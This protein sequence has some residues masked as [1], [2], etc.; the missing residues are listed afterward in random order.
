MINAVQGSYVACSSNAIL[1]LRDNL[2]VQ[3]SRVKNPER[4]WD[5]LVVPNFY[6]TLRNF[7]EK[8]RSQVLTD[9]AVI[10][11]SSVPFVC[12]VLQRHVPRKDIKRSYQETTNALICIVFILK[13]ALKHLK[14]SHI[15]RS[16][17]DHQGAH[18]VP[19]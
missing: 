4:R 13:L 11:C 16:I 2:S 15:F 18:V 10:T 5:R 9:I 12:Y 8:R 6:Y 17:D 7:P 14:S 19:C 3:Y 1:T